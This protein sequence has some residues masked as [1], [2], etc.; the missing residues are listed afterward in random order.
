MVRCLLCLAVGFLLVSRDAGAQSSPRSTPGNVKPDTFL[1]LKLASV[2]EILYDHL[3]RLSRG[4][5]I[6]VEQV[7]SKSPAAQAGLK[8]SDILLSYDGKDLK[9]TAQFARLVRSGKAE[10]KAPLVL[11]RGGEKVTLD[12]ALAQAY[13]LADPEYRAASKTGKPP[14]VTVKATMLGGGK[15]KV[16]LEYT[17]DGTNKTKTVDYEGSLD[18]IE[19]QVKKNLPASVQELAQV[20]LDR[21]RA[22]KNR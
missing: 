16:T 22:R 13:K 21:L 9:D 14:S 19:T 10:H 2:P 18:D 20:A 15:M 7:K 5:G 3:P 8:R 12:V 4:V 1:G 17:P 11:L 6:V